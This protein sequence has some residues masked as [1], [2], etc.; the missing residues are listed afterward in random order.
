M[1][2][3]M[4]GVMRAMTELRRCDACGALSDDGRTVVSS[5][6]IGSWS[7]DHLCGDC[8]S[9]MREVVDLDE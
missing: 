8:L 1:L 2:M 6:E 4:R 5:V 7:E 3:P 9:K